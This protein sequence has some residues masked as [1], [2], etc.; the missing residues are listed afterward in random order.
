MSGACKTLRTHDCLAVVPT[1]AAFE[2]TQS[3]QV[4][5]GDFIA[6]SDEESGVHATPRSQASEGKSS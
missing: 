5:V 4:R 1:R 3:R 6:L 2:N